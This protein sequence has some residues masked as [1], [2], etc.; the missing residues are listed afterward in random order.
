MAFVSI[1]LSEDKSQTFTG[2]EFVELK[3]ICLQ[4]KKPVSV[5]VK[6][7]NI[8]NEEVTVLLAHLTPEQPQFALDDPV[9]QPMEL[10]VKGPGKVHVAAIIDLHNDMLLDDDDEDMDD[11]EEPSEE[12][13]KKPVAKPPKKPHTKEK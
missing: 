9:A 12:E 2:E 11:D 5:F 3:N 10:S 7:Q 6:T 13:E 4:G 1:I 8:D